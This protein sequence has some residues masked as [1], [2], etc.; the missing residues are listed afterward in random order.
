VD[1]VTSDPASR[2]LAVNVRV[3][4]EVSV[5]VRSQVSDTR[6]EGDVIKVGTVLA[7]SDPATQAERLSGCCQTNAN[8][9][10]FAQSHPVSGCAELTPLAE[11]C[12]PVDHE[13]VPVGE[14]ALRIEKI[15]IGGM[16]SGELL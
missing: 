12:G 7:Q 3:A 9:S 4:G 14:R 2:V 16:D 5:K 15:V 10:P 1:V 8:Q 11:I 6:V 13:V